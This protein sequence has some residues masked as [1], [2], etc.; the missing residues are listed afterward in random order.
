MREELS[1]PV[2]RSWQDHDVKLAQLHTELNRI[3]EALRRQILR[4]E[5]HDDPNHP[6]IALAK[7]R[8]EE[9]SAR[10]DV[11]VEDIKDHDA[12]EPG[13]ARQEDIEAILTAI[14]DLRGRLNV[15]D[16]EGLVAIFKAFDIGVVY[17]KPNQTIALAATIRSDLRFDKENP[18]QG[19]ASSGMFS[20][21]AG[22]GLEH[23]SPTVYK[24]LEV[25]QLC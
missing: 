8:I 18:R 20:K 22:A 2:A 17:D 9:L 21:V 16:P 15:T 1:D 4:I 23:I 25:R 6:V 5:E 19:V 12:H 7:R 13:S 24:L 10:R 11:I 14:P 3:D